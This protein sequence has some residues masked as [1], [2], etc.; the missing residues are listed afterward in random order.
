M[1]YHTFSH[2]PGIGEK[3]EQR[4][5]RSGILT[6][7][8]FLAASDIEGISSQRK[9]LYDEK[10][11]VCQKALENRDA[12]YLG[13][14]LKRREHWRL[15]DVFR[16]DVV[17]LDIE[18]NGLHPTQGG[19]PT[20]VC[21][22]DGFDSLSLV[23]G[24]NLTADNLNRYLSGYKMVITFYGAGFDIPFLL[25][26]LPG[27]RFDIPHF[28]LCFAARRLGINGGLKSIEEQYGIVRD[29]SLQG[30]TG[31]DAIHLWQQS[32]MGNLEARE[33][34]LTYNRADT[35]HLL[36]LADILY[37]KMRAACGIETYTTTT[38]Q[39]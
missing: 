17:C 21:L 28:D 13:Q 18:T 11:F 37:K 33:L 36:P 24:E 39:S 10:L 9:K 25:M 6:W 38:V 2:L 3:L 26:T 20:V 14:V 30:L 31:F 5:W 19:Y 4:I 32:C 15:F 22:Y 8:A 34:L 23:Y 29:T 16:D 7:D 1:I 35:E 27:V 12:V